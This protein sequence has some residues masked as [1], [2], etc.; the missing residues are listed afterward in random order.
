MEQDLLHG[1]IEM[2]VHSAPDIVPRKSDD[3][4]LVKAA[5]EAGMGGI[6]IK[7]HLGS[8]VERAILLQQVVSNISVFGGVVLNHPVGGLNP[9]AVE[10]FLQMGAKEVWMPTFSAQAMLDE[11]RSQNQAEKNETSERTWKGEN[12][13]WAKGGLGIS[14]LDQ[15]G[16]LRQ[17]VWQILEIIAASEAIL[18]TG[19]I[20]IPETHALIDAAQE[21]KVK[22]LLITHPEYMAAMTLDDQIALA[23]RGVFFERCYIC[24]SPVSQFLGPDVSFELL[25]ENIRAVGIESN[26][27]ATDFGQPAN[28]HPVKGMRDFLG[29]LQE[30]GFRESELETMAIKTPRALLNLN[31]TWPTS[32]SETVS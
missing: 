22:R 15:R 3:I 7:S 28:D 16:K 6:L 18:G 29:R 8:T 26:V 27:L 2:H 13:P 12:W 32:S 5:A 17:E 4:A 9:N 23:K 31:D 14:I 19:H 30:A 1:T 25:V 21:L 11:R 10:V 20:S 24:A